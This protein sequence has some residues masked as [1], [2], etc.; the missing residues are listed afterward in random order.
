MPQS[1]QGSATNAAQRPR[2]SAVVSSD[3]KQVETARPHASVLS[4]TSAD[5]VASVKQSI[6]HVEHQVRLHDEDLQR[7]VS[8]FKKFEAEA[9][10]V[11]KVQEEHI[12]T[13]EKEVNEVK[14][15]LKA[16]P[17]SSES[18]GSAGNE[19]SGGTLKNTL[20]VSLSRA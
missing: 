6:V 4:K 2:S 3:D 10:R 20:S 9:T 16:W 1:A 15:A 11:I 19:N 5:A 12:A 17:N 13:L 8:G 7:L 18:S 14:E